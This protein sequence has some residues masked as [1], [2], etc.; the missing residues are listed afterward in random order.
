MTN[1]CED[2]YDTSAA[3]FSEDLGAGFEEGSELGAATEGAVRAASDP[4][5]EGSASSEDAIII[6]NDGGEESVHFR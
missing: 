2:T 4:A 3:R 1:A 5:A 6:L